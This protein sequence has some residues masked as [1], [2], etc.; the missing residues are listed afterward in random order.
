MGRNSKKNFILELAYQMVQL[1]APLQ[2]RVM[3]FF[4]GSAAF[5][6]V[7]VILM[8]AGRNLRFA[9]ALL[10]SLYIA[11]LGIEIVIRYHD[12]KIICKR[13]VCISATQ[14]LKSQKIILIM[15]EMDD[16]ATVGSGVHK[17]LI[18]CNKNELQ[19]LKEN[20]IMNIFFQPSNAMEVTAWEIVDYAGS[21]K[22]QP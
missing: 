8:I 16:Q 9:P 10:F 19:M 11:Y 3:Q 22:C 2:S 6:L 14:V 13:M 12:G 5:T 21:S 18:S 7:I 20:I 1:P 17:F 4:V 15:R